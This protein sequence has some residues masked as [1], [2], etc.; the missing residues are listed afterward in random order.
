MRA[1]FVLVFLF[2]GIATATT[3]RPWSGYWG[4]VDWDATSEPALASVGSGT[5]NL[6]YKDADEHL[7]RREWSSGQFWGATEDLGAWVASP[8]AAVGASDGKYHVFACGPYG[9]VY[10]WVCESRGV[11]APPRW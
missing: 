2:P 4:L 6:F 3:S 9:W 8:P 5:M 7:K 10:E 1:A 11:C